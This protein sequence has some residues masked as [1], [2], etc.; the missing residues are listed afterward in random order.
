M[1][2]HKKYR[3]KSLY[4]N[5]VR[6]QRD[7]LEKAL[8]SILE[9]YCAKSPKPREEAEAEAKEFLQIIEDS[10]SYQFGMNHSIAYCLLGYLCGY[11]RH[12]YPMEF[13][14]AFLNNAQND[15]DVT[16]GTRMMRLYGIKMSNP[17]YGISRGDFFFDKEHKV[18]YKGL[19]SVKYMSAAAAEELYDLSKKK[20]Y[21]YFIDLLKDIDAETTLNSRQINILTK[22][23]FFSEFGNQC[24]L[25]RLY[26]LFEFFKKGEAK[27]IKRSTVDESPF[28]DVIRRHS[29]SKTKS[30]AESKSYTVLDM[31][32]LLH[33]VEDMLRSFHLADLSDLIK[34]RNFIDVMGYAGYVS[35]KQ[36]DRRK[37]YVREVYPLLRKRD[38]KQFGYSVL[39][40][41]LG[42]GI[43]SRF[44]VF[45]RVYDK[46][47]IK[48]EDII[49]CKDY[50]RDGP[51]FTL[52]SYE[53]IY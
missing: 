36:E 49:Y 30:G 15:E 41:S 14:T 26:D 7:R 39:T 38:G 33:D 21:T 22:I 9:G 40:Q 18:I 46:D 25:F 50:V 1:R 17:K 43:E 2:N 8:P 42:S 4:D 28:A 24:E 3:I 51:Y 53:H 31:D 5:N 32:A 6:K 27:Q 37:L 35:N 45:N 11:Y 34:V 23:D 29:T 52:T 20:K 48:K 47:P 19:N 16:N 44:T 10:A 13:I 12:Y